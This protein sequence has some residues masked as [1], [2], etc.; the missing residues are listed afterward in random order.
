M[1]EGIAIKEPLYRLS[2]RFRNGELI[3]WVMQ[4]PVDSRAIQ[5]DTT[6]MVVTSV[7]VQ[8]PSQ[9]A[10]TTFVNIRDMSFLRC[11]KVTLEQLAGEHRSAGIR[12]SA[13]K[14][15]AED[16]GPKSLSQ[17]SFF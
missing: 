6:F 1:N 3:S 10:E 7:S 11:E 12:S 4:N 15:G 8:N 14:G 9:C 2:V 13:G 5:P 17:V 16:T